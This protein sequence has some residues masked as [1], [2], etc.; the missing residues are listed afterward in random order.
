MS[1][2][3]NIP[4]QKQNQNLLIPPKQSHSFHLIPHP[5]SLFLSLFLPFFFSPHNSKGRENTCGKISPESLVSENL[6][7]LLRLIYNMPIASVIY[8]YLRQLEGEFNEL[9]DNKKRSQKRMED[10]KNL[11]DQDLERDDECGICMENYAKMVLPNC[12]H[13][14]CITCFHDWNARSQSCPFCRGNLKRV[15]STDLWVLTRNSDVI[16]AVTLAKENLRRFYLYVENIPVVMPATHVV[17]YD[18]ML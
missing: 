5:L 9:E 18:Y 12:G 8:P 10:R 17:V 3:S 13:S 11:S 7:R 6:S 16:D 4:Q 15:S 14:M 2:T 1:P